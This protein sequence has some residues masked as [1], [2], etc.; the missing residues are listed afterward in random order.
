M[1]VQH[2]VSLRIFFSIEGETIGGQ[3]IQEKDQAGEMRMLVLSIPCFLASVS[4][5][6]A[7]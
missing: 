5:L 4:V 7:V 2:E 6:L 3:A 1:R